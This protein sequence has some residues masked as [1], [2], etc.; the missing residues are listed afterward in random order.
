MEEAE[1]KIIHTP[2]KRL[3]CSLAITVVLFAAEAA[4]GWL[5]NSLAL[6]SDAGHVLTD[7]F[8]LV[9]SLIAV[10]ISRRP[11]DWRATFGYQRI[12]ILAALINGASLIIISFFIAVEAYQRVQS[13]PDI[14]VGLM[15]IVA[16]GGLIGNLLMAWLLHGEHN[17]LNVRSAWLHVVGDTLSSVGVIAAGIIIYFTGWGLIDPI[18]SAAVCIMIL[19]SGVRVVKDALWIF[20]DL[21]PAGF[22]PEEIAAKL[23]DIPGIK[24]IHDVHVWAIS[25]GIPAFSAHIRIN[26][27]K[28]SEADAVRLEIEHR[29]EHMGISHTVIQLECADCGANGLYCEQKGASGIANH[30]YCH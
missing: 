6:L 2:Q 20:L 4:G 11:T 14:D 13:P 29:L 15:L 27:R 1:R 10:I 7:G 19:I 22:H 8:A 18:I 24:D 3:L 12:G 17:D 9:L 16:T 26:D 5:S 28:I 23:S 25:H 30:G 21:T